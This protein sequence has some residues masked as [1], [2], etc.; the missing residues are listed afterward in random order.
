[1]HGGGGNREGRSGQRKSK[2]AREGQESEEGA[3]SPFYS[4]SGILGYCQ[5]TVGQSLDRMLTNTTFQSEK[6]EAVTLRSRTKML[7]LSTSTQHIPE[8]LTSCLMRKTHQIA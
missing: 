4:E 5:V 6:L 8:V 3:S 1:V 7:S 2:R